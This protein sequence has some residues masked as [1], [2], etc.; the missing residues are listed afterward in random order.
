M[1]YILIFTIVSLLYTQYLSNYSL[2]RSTN[3]VDEG[4]LGNVIIDIRKGP[5]DRFYIGTGGGLGYVDLLDLDSPLFYTIVNDSLPIGGNPSMKTYI[6]D[7]ELMIIESKS[8]HEEDN[9]VNEEFENLKLN[10]SNNH[11]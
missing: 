9:E 2:N 5:N 4:L 7:D 3:G 10:L 1:R 11:S 8:D 6:V